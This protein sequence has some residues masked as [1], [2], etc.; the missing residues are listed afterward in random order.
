MPRRPLGWGS[1]CPMIVQET[2]WPRMAGRRVRQAGL[3]GSVAWLE[4]TRAAVSKVKQHNHDTLE[5]STG[6]SKSSFG[7]CFKMSWD[8]VRGF[9]TH[10]RCA[11]GDGHGRQG[12]GMVRHA[13]NRWGDRQ[14]RTARPTVN[15]ACAILFQ[16]RSLPASCRLNEERLLRSSKVSSREARSNNSR[17]SAS[18]SA[19][20][21]PWSYRPDNRC[22]CL[23]TLLSFI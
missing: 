22:E 13:G 21:K 23:D 17:V 16:C 6:S 19:C 1:V 18:T 3:R 20:V 14:G 11:C 12:L 7:E 9:A 4:A 15:R 5:V 8:H 10:G 2:S